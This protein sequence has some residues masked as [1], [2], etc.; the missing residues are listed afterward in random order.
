MVYWLNYW[1]SININSQTTDYPFDDP[2]NH[3]D[4]TTMQRPMHE[5]IGLQGDDEAGKKRG[6][7]DFYNLFAN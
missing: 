3:I 2:L 1:L 5:G 7:P 4:A 6:I